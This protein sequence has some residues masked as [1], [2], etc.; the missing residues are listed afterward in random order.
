MMV[1]SPGQMGPMV[2]TISESGESLSRRPNPGTGHFNN[3]DYSI[4]PNCSRS[5]FHTSFSPEA[6]DHSAAN[7]LVT[8]K[9]STP[10]T[11]RVAAGSESNASSQP[12]PEDE[13]GDLEMIFLSIGQLNSTGID[14]SEDDNTEQQSNSTFAS[15]AQRNMA[16]L[17]QP[18]TH[19]QSPPNGQGQRQP[20]SSSAINS[21]PHGPTTAAPTS[22]PQ[23]AAVVTRSTDGKLITYN[24]DIYDEADI[25]L[26]NE[27]NANNIR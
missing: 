5:L 24:P 8:E 21:S 20:L 23:S 3:L 1:P 4:S 2:H 14:E 12:K 17:Q 15:V 27:K 25:L 6:A 7:M 10:T 26:T 19:M 11:N 22:P 16:A 9:D 18:L 13:D